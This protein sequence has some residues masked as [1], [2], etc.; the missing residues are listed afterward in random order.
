MGSGKSCRMTGILY[1]CPACLMMGA[2]RRHCGHCKSSNTTSASV[3][4]FGGR[5]D[6]S[7]VFVAETLTVKP[8]DNIP[9]SANKIAVYFLVIKILDAAILWI[10]R[11]LHGLYYGSGRHDSWRAHR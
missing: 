9:K 4:P 5:N 3:E 10:C 8:A 2:E 7:L 6:G 11:S 1:D